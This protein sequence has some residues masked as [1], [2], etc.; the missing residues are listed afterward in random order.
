[1]EEPVTQFVASTDGVRI[2]Y[3][4]QGRGPALILLHPYGPTR[5]IWHESGY[6]ERLQ[7]HFTVIT[8]DN[9]NVGES[10]KPS[11]MAGY[12]IDH[13]LAD[14]HAVADACGADTFLVWGHSFGATITTQLSAASPRLRAAVIAGSFYGND[15]HTF[16][17]EG[18]LTDLQELSQAKAA[19]TLDTLPPRAR[20]FA[21][22]TNLDEG[23]AFWRVLSDWPVVE[24]KDARC[25]AYIY[26]GSE[27][28]NISLE[29][30]STRRAEVEA[31]GMQLH[32]FDGLNHMQELT[33]ID[34]VL[35]PVLAFLKEHRE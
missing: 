11:G 7:E 21:E 22:Q 2:A 6:P 18:P 4:V 19:G 27:E 33:E 35:P 20:E 24:P 29:Q 32:V 26:F 28:E 1:M 25:P 13:Y 34:T 17:Q 8:M 16:V 31:L 10:E 23:I 12:T 9:R 3:D 30:I 14:I 5:R 15:F